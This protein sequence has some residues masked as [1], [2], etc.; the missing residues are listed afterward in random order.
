MVKFRGRSLRFVVHTLTWATAIAALVAGRHL[1]GSDAS[2]EQQG[3]SVTAQELRPGGRVGSVAVADLNADGR[4][5]IMAARLDT[6]TLSVYL[7][8]GQG[9]FRVAPGSPFA[10]GPAPE[11]IA[12]ADFN[13]DGR[14]DVAVTNHETDHLTVLFGDGKGGLAASPESR[15]RAGSRPHQHGLAAGDFNGDGQADLTI[16]S[17]DDDAVFVL[18]GDGRSGFRGPREQ[19][20]VGR[21]PYWRVRAG[22]LNGD[23]RTDIVTTDSEGASVTVLLSNE[24]GFASR[25]LSIDPRPFAVAIGDLNGDRHPDLAVVHYQVNAGGSDRVTI[26]LGDGTGAFAPASGSPFPTG[27]ASTDVAIGD[28]NGDGIGDVAVANNGSDDVTVLYGS[29]SSLRAA[30]GSPFS[31]GDAPTSIVVADVNGDR[32]AEVI[33]GNWGSGDVTVRSNR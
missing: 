15:V 1:P 10:A 26:L 30:E 22:D 13:R 11:D 12:T 3:T 9:R 32:R 25:R 27:R 18:H 21:A 8:D 2:A 33:T 24:R 17:R 29:T 14:V 6:G 4:P 20:S 28:I 31:A 7:S 16:D 23:R 5:D 19:H